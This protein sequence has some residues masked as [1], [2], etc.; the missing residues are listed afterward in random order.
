MM[1]NQAPHKMTKTTTLQLDD[2]IRKTQ[3][4]KLNIC[5]NHLFIL[6]EKRKID[7]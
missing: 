7:V 5:K 4:K 6:K 3:K 1:Q 2:E